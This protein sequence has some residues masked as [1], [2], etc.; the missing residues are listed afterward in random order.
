MN[1]EL[2]KHELEE[3]IERSRAELAALADGTWMKLAL[4]N[5]GV[6]PSEVAR[7]ATGK[8]TLQAANE[9]LRRLWRVGLATRELELLPG[10]GRRY[11]YQLTP[12]ALG[13]A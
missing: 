7:D 8:L 10:G 4:S 1:T 6:T 5:K 3:L 9:R 11:R 13:D 12:E 2:R